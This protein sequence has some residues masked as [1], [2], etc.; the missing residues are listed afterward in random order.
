MMAQATN[1]PHALIILLPPL[2]LILGAELIVQQRWHPAL[3]GM[4]AGVAASL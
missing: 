4:L 1:R 2:A 3:V